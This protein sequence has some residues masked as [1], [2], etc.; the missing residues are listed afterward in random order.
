MKSIAAAEVPA[1]GDAADERK[2]LAQNYSLL[3]ETNVRLF[4]VVDSK[5][6]FDP[7]LTCRAP[8]DKTIRAD[9]QLLRYNFEAHSL[10]K[11][12]WI[13][14]SANSADLLTK[15]DSP[16]IYTLQLLLFNGKPELQS[17]KTQSTSSAA[18]L[19]YASLL[20]RRGMFM[21]WF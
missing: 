7:L 12:I 6:L 3:P 19:G 2:L 1:A 21:S 10:N 8:G 17:D 14:C 13:Q 5:D 18:P 15:R 20:R 4:V 9:V 16:L 11:L